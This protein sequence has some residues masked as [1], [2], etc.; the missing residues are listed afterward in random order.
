M[1]LYAND[2]EFEVKA[3]ER[4][5]P[6]VK[7]EFITA[8]EKY[9]SDEVIDLKHEQ[10]TNLHEKLQDKKPNEA[11]LIRLTNQ[12]KK[13]S[14]NEIKN[15]EIFLNSFKTIIDKKGLTDKQVEL[16]DS[17]ISGEFWQNQDIQLIKTEVNGF[18]IKISI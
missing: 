16:I 5:T 2:F 4:I 14:P 3:V 11:E 6:K 7:A 8:F 17:D 13:F 10:I 9:T 12:F 15:D 18:C 1:K